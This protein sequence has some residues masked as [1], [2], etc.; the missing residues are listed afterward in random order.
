MA[1]NS[2][3][4][5]LVKMEVDYAEAV[6]AQIAKSEELVRAGHLQE[7]LD[8]LIVLEK[9]ARQSGD[10]FSSVKVLC[11]IVNL[12][13]QAKNYDMLTEMMVV[14]SKRRSQYK[15]AV[16]AM[17]QEVV[18]IV[19]TIADRPTQLKVIEAIRTV[20]EG[21]IYVEVERARITYKLAL[22]L[23]AEGKAKEGA[24]I[25][26]DLQIE[27]YGSME[28][29]EKME[30]L[31]EQMR[32]CLAK[33]DYVR[34]QIISRKVS[35]KFFEEEAN[36]DLKL[37]YFK[38]M[39]QLDEHDSK[40]LSVA[41]HYGAIYNTKKIKENPID[42]LQA[43]QCLLSYLVLA[44]FDNEQHDMMHRM[45]ADKNLDK[46]PPYKRLLK[47]FITE[48]IIQWTIFS[49]ELEK[50]LRQ[51]SAELPAV[52]VFQPNAEGTARWLQLRQRTTEHNIRI[53][54]LYYSRVS[55][56]RL[57]FLLSLTPLQLEEFI[58]K[59]VT[60]K[61]IFARI[62]RPSGTVVFRPHKNVDATLDDWAG[63]VA[64]LMEM[65]SQTTHLIN[66]EEMV[67][68]MEHAAVAVADKD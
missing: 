32:L 30:M 39:I 10:T 63:N 57:A 66:K 17:V 50:D 56:N 7:A 51:G 43:L 62:D 1:L 47:S 24:E 27:T 3:D 64:K 37:K 36:Q 8:G 44:P 11:A 34:T 15:Q 42:S 2:V 59:L 55:L 5:K 48:E 68:G 49:S 45:L 14:M 20:T 38:L 60:K 9:Q 31:L 65:I 67:H 23:E 35:L 46:I 4:G 12:C 61:T 16:T 21:K 29:R 18:K 40:F 33:Q 54:A 53:A 26:Q 25:L 28:R 52:Y 58:G 19:D 41:R 22:M 6:A 13:A